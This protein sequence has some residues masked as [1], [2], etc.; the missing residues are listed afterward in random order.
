MDT[1]FLLFIN[2]SLIA[3]CVILFVALT[4]AWR[5]RLNAGFEKDFKVESPK[6]KIDKVERTLSCN[7][8]NWIAKYYAEAWYKTA[9]GSDYQKLVFYDEA[10]K[11]N[12]GDE[13]ELVK[14]EE[15]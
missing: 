13:I 14:I 4:S 5:V 1:N 8:H 7:G 2:G 10:G 12:I 3:I 15:K 9:K 11:Y 6:I